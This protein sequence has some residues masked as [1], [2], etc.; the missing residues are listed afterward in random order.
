M[1]FKIRIFQLIV[2]VLLKQRSLSQI[3]FQC[4]TGHNQI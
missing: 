2:K 4:L 3:K 1:K